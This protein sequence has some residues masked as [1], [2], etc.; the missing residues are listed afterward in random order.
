MFVILLKRMSLPNKAVL[1]LLAFLLIAFKLNADVPQQQERFLPLSEYLLESNWELH[2]AEDNI[3][4]YTQFV[5]GSQFIAVKLVTEMDADAQSVLKALGNG[6]SC[7]PWVQACKSARVLERKSDRDFIGYSH[8]NFPWPLSDR[9][10]IYRTTIDVDAEKETITIMRDS[11]HKYPFESKL[12]QMIGKNKIDIV[13]LLPNK[14]RFTW[15]LHVDPQGKAPVS[16]VNKKMVVMPKKDLLSL[17]KIL[18][19]N[20]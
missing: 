13:E 10:M 16:A 5:D 14:V 7:A 19:N 1:N 20:N 11:V 9:Y 4:V 18:H 15:A 3:S 2:S 12:T 17:K 8:L 6:E